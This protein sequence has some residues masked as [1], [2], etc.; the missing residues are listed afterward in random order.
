M[1]VPP[2]TTGPLGQPRGV[3]FGILMF[4]ITLGI[5]GVYWI[6]KSCEEIKQHANIGVGGL[7]GLVIWLVIGIVMCFELPSEIGKM[8]KADGQEAPFS[9][10]IGLWVLLPL[11]GGIVWFVKVQRALNRYWEGKAGPAPAA[12]PVPAA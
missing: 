1:N 11:V 7:L 8:Y 9:G 4:I 12:A 3:G 5:Y 2:S 10:W 6:Y